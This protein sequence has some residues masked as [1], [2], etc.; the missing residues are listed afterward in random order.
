LDYLTLISITP[1]KR[2]YSRVVTFKAA[3]GSAVQLYDFKTNKTRIVFGP[4]HIMLAPYENISVLSLSGGQPIQEGF[5][6]TLSIELGPSQIR[7]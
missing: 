2:D 7:D 4:E 3:Q 1:K 5:L 6:R